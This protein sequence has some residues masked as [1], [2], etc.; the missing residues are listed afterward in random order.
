MVWETIIV[1]GIGA[2][3]SVV[4][5]EMVRDGY[6]VLAHVWTPLQRLHNWHHRVF[7]KDFTPVSEDIY[8][9][10]HLYNDVPEA[11]VMTGAIALLAL[12]LQNWGMVLG[13]VYGLGFLITALA[14]SQGWLLSTDLTHAPGPLTEVP[15]VWRVNRSYHWKHHFDDVNAYYAGSFTLSD[16]LMGTS[17]S[18]KNK[19]VAVTGASGTLGRALITELLHQGAKPIALTTSPQ[20]QFP[21]PVHVQ[22]WQLGQES[23][24]QA[25]LQK[26]DI[27]IINHGVNVHRDRTPAAIAQSL[28]VNALS[29]LAL[30]DCFFATVNTP[31][32]RATKEVWVNTSEAEVGPA[33]SPLYETSKRLVGD[34]VTLK[35]QDAPCIVRKLIL[36]PFKSNLNPIG[37]LSATW[38]AKQILFLAKRDFRNLIITINPLT[39]FAFPLKEASQAL[40][41][42][43][44]SR[45]PD[46]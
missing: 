28:N 40:Y 46:G 29:V 27:L 4:A 43:L 37:V 9:K 21:D 6:H 41:F 20:A 10:A 17:L 15:G 44:F 38:V 13:V 42:R 12:A 16:K 19:T 31:T 45:A 35:R 2:I 5:V 24:L 7:K 26:V 1:Q 39:Y 11:L 8:R 14:R 36:G 25:L 34:L 22:T 33:F 32:A 3:A 30:M 23:A 18:L